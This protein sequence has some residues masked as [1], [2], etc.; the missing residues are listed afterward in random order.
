MGCVFSGQV[1]FALTRKIG[2]GV[3]SE[4]DQLSF[5]FVGLLKDDNADEQGLYLSGFAEDN[6]K[7]TTDNQITSKQILSAI[8]LGSYF[9]SH[10]Y[11]L[12]KSIASLSY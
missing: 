9:F 11:N 2:E 12:L 6:G 5:L 8:K 1:Q 7:L 10:E 4:V 3:L